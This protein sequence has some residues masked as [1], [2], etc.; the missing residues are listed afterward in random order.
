MRET[1]HVL[2]TDDRIE[3]AFISFLRFIPF[4]AA[5]ALGVM[6]FAAGLAIPLSMRLD[7]G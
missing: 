6:F 3:R 2:N 1:A 7:P 4:W 5:A